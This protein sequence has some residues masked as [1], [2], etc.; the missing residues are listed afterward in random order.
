MGLENELIKQYYEDLIVEERG[1]KGGKIFLDWLRMEIDFQNIKN[2]FRLRQSREKGDV[3][4]LM[5]HGG[6]IPVEEL[7]RLNGI[8]DRNEF[9]DGLRMKAVH[10]PL[11]AALEE[12][13]KERPIHEV[14]IALT[15]VLLQQMAFQ[16]R[17]HPFSIYPA[18]TYLE[19]KRYEVA[20]I[21]TIA[22]GKKVNLPSEEIKGYLVI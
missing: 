5:I 16:A 19:E 18:L 11:Q 13:R 2:L 1:V 8:E 4:P 20:N 15:R 6:R 12:F 10:E 9:I 21:R 17:M 7:V 22:R 14:E 3:F